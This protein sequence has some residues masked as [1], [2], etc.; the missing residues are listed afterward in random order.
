[1]NTISS[2]TLSLPADGTYQVL[3]AWDKANSHYI[4]TLND[5]RIVEANS[6]CPEDVIDIQDINKYLLRG[7]NL[8][9]ALAASTYQPNAVGNEDALGLGYYND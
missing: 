7:F 3:D 9:G 6:V 8:L 1:M 4:I 2:T 5:G